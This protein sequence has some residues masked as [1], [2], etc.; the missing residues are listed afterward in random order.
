MHN[1]FKGF[2]N[3]AS[4]FKE[5]FYDLKVFELED[6]DPE[7]INIKNIKIEK[8]L[9]LGKRVEYFF[10][11]IIEN[12]SNY[13]MLMKNIQIIKNKNT[14]GEMDFIIYDK[15]KDKN[16][17]VELQYKYYLYDESFENEIDRFIGPNRNDTLL[18][19]LKKLKNKQFPLLFKEETKLYLNDIDLE[20]MEQ[21]ML[22]KAH[23]FLPRYLKNKQVSIINSACISGYYIKYEEFIEDDFFK[24]IELFLPHRYDWLSNPKTNQSWKKYDEVKEE[25]DM[26]ININASPLVWCKYIQKD[27]TIIERFF[28]T[29]W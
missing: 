12:S 4:L 2:C 13:K 11:A 9:P 29:W 7:K 8:K 15:I 23:I 17:H 5:E 28:I 27:K 18:L 26:F 25:I 21:K 16:I 3:T 20:N 19:K 6:I 24:K 22:F 10:D 14:L 1:Q